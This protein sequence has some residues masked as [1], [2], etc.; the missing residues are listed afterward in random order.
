MKIKFQYPTKRKNKKLR[1]IQLKKDELIPHIAQYLMGVIQVN[2]KLLELGRPSLYSNLE[3]VEDVSK[4][5]SQILSDDENWDIK[6]ENVSFKKLV[7]VWHDDNKNCMRVYQNNIYHLTYVKHINNS[8]YAQNV[9]D[10][11]NELIK[12][13]F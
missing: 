11:L 8:V 3:Y 12:A 13:V 7:T 2:N 4:Y 1:K 6:G 9:E 5:I 10:A